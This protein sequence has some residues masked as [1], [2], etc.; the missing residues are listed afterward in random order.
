MAKAVNE[1]CEKPVPIPAL[2]NSEK[3]KT[4]NILKARYQFYNL[5]LFLTLAISIFQKGDFIKC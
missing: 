5:F 1:S 3:K 4:T 2:H